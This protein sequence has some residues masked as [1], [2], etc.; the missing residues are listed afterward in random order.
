[1]K[2]LKS[3][4]CSAFLSAVL[5]SNVFAADTFTTV[6]T[7]YFGNIVSAV[8]SSFNNI[9]GDDCPIKICQSCKPS[10]PGCRPPL[11]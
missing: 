7:D 8:L 1:M 5:V 11:H 9:D 10:D 2:K 4:L 3:V 6:I